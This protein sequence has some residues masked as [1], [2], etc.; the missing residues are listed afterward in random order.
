MVVVMISKKLLHELLAQAENNT[1][2]FAD[3]EFIIEIEDLVLLGEELTDEQLTR[4]REL[5]RS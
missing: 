1:Y 5:A 2:K 4:L 3:L